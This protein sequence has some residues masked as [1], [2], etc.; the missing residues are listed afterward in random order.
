MYTQSSNVKL[1]VPG[2]KT[3][4]A[5]AGPPTDPL[6]DIDDVPN[7]G[8]MVFES[9]PEFTLRVEAGRNW[10]CPIGAAIILLEPL[11]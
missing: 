7:L 1:P 2:P 9:L 4:S 11:G 3:S 6:Q 10:L 5:I 8:A